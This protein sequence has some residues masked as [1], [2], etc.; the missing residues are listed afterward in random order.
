[1]GIS[2]RCD[3]PQEWRDNSKYLGREGADGQLR[4]ASFAC[5]LWYQLEKK[6]LKAWGNVMQT[7]IDYFRPR[8]ERRKEFFSSSIS[9]LGKL[10]SG[11]W[12]M[13]LRNDCISNKTCTGIRTRRSKIISFHSQFVF[14]VIKAALHSGSNFSKQFPPANCGWDPNYCVVTKKV[15]T[16]W[17]TSR[18]LPQGD[19]V[20]YFRK[21]PKSTHEAHWGEPM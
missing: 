3:I 12:M 2:D 7:L 16:R 21:A 5:Y 20:N 10:L 19:T 6:A 4:S 11:I 15:N 17:N 14:Q 18:D 1:M 9:G 8:K 13:M